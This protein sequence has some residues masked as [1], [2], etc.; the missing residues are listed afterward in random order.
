MSITLLSIALD[1]LLLLLLRIFRV[2]I[3][4]FVSKARK[5]RGNWILRRILPKTLHSH[6]G[7]EN[8]TLCLI[9]D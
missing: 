2:F 8:L 9:V 4:I 7:V 6:L 1:C 5:Q 3:R